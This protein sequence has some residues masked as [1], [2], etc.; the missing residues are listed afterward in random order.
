MAKIPGK[1]REVRVGDV[2]SHWATGYLR[3]GTV[4]KVTKTYIWL[5]YTSPS[6]G[7]HHNTKRHR[8]EVLL[9]TRYY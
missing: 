3:Q 8:A 6:T 1:E 5:E 7:E 2:I 9:G 4:T